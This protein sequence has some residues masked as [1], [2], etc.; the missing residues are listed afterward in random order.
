MVYVG[1]DIKARTKDDALRIMSLMS[2]GEV[3]SD[4]EIIFIEEKELH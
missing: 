3:N 2:G 1:K 4:S